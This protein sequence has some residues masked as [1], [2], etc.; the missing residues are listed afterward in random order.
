MKIIDILNEKVDG[1]LVDGFEFSY[2]GSHYAYFK[3]VDEI[4]DIVTGTNI[5]AIYELDKILSDEVEVIEEN[6][7]IEKLEISESNTEIIDDFVIKNREKTNELVRAVN[8]I[9]K[10]REEK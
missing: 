10:E 6:K 3:K 1:T 7:E 8:K 4:Q 9:N 5:G 2:E